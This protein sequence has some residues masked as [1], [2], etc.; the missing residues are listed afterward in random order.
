MESDPR[1]LTITTIYAGPD[2]SRYVKSSKPRFSIFT[3]AEACSI[4]RQI[5]NGLA[6][7]HSKNIV[8]FDIKPQ[9]ILLSASVAKICDFGLA[10]RIK[11]NTPVDYPG[12]T[13]SYLAPE[14]LNDQEGSFP[15][16]IWALGGTVLFLLRIIPLPKTPTNFK[17]IAKNKE[18]INQWQTQLTNHA[19]NY[20]RQ[21]IRRLLLLHLTK[22]P[23][24]RTTAS[25]LIT[26][27]WEALPLPFTDDS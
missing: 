17:S 3:A 26:E 8:H 7:I 13:F 21:S 18:Q 27:N 19:A 12:G 15:L 25:S 22:D 24:E 14:C 16:D 23:A 2:L 10:Q 20:E 5:A 9:N 4:W 11:D 1:R 6:F